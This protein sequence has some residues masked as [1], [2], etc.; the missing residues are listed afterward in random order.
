M[1]HDVEGSHLSEMTTQWSVVLE[2]SSSSPERARLAL[3]T[4]LKRYSGAVHRYLLGALRDPDAAADLEQEFAARF[5]RGGFRRADPGKGRFRDYVKQALRNLV[6]DHYR[7]ERARPLA[8][9]RVE[10]R[11]ACSDGLAD[12]DRAFTESWRNHLLDRAWRALRDDEL[13][14]KRPHFTVLSARVDHPD[15]RSADLALK[16]TSSLG[17]PISTGAFRQ[18]VVRARERFVELL[19]HEIAATL[20]SPDAE[21][22]EEELAD[23]RLLEFCRPKLRRG[24]AP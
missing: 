21:Q 17:R 6:T 24:V 2:A 14:T 11:V 15:L 10:E 8:R 18:A 22:I 3:A 5:L 23:L 9:D 12:F 20:D 16:V 4:L 13:E 1:D 7:K 19:L